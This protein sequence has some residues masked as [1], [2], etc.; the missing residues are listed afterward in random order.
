MLN[1]SRSGLWFLSLIPADQGRLDLVFNGTSS[2][3]WLPEAESHLPYFVA[4]SS[5]QF[6]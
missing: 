6:P 3:V 2:G 5:G 4:G 1:Y